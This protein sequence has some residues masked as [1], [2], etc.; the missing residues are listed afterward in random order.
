MNFLQY[1]ANALH[2]STYMCTVLYLHDLNMDQS[3]Y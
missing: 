3:V 1:N 2:A